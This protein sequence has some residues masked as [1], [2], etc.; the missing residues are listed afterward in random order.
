MLQPI[1]RLVGRFDELFP[2]ALKILGNY[3]EPTVSFFS[4]LCIH[5]T[6]RTLADWW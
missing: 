4:G 2:E 6:D 5:Q 3:S 1:Y